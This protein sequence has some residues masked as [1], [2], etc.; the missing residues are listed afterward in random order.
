MEHGSILNGNIRPHRVS[1]QWQS[2]RNWWL[3]VQAGVLVGLSLALPLYLY[4]RQ[5]LYQ[6]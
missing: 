5:D 2:T 1:Y 6:D 4:F 3:A